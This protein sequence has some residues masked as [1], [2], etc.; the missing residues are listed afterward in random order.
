MKEIVSVLRKSRSISIRWSIFRTLLLLILLISGSLFLITAFTARS[1][2]K[3]LSERLIEDAVNDSDARLQGFFR[4]VRDDIL[5]LRDLIERG[6][7]N[8]R[9]PQDV[10]QVFAAILE[11]QP[12]IAAIFWGGSDGESFLVAKLEGRWIA[13]HVPADASLP[14]RRSVFDPKSGAVTAVEP[15]ERYDPRERPWYR[16]ATEHETREVVWTAP[17][18]F[19]TNDVIGVTGATEVRTPDGERIV[20]A[21]DVAMTRVL[22]FLHE[23]RPTPGG[24][25]FLLAPDGQMLTAAHFGPMKAVAAE[26]MA[27]EGVPLDALMKHA[28]MEGAPTVLRHGADW[29]CGIRPIQTQGGQ[30]FK[31]GVLIPQRDL[32]GD[33]RTFRVAL[34]LVTLGALVVATVLTLWVSRGY[35]DPIRKL[36]AQSQRIEKLDMND[37]LQLSSSLREV[38][39]LADAQEKMR[40]ALDSFARYVPVTVVRDL[41][42]QGAAAEIG[43]ELR[44]ITVIFSDIAG[45]TS[46]AERMTPEELTEHMG[47]YFDVMV[48]TFLKHDATVDKFIGDAIMAFWGAPRTLENHAAA[49]TRGVL[50]AKAALDELNTRWEVEGKVPLPTRF[51]IATGP[52]TVGNVG[53]AFRLSY[54]AL[55]DTVNL[56]QRLESLNNETNTWILASAETREAAGEEFEWREIGATQVKGREKYVSV[57]ELLGT[58]NESAA[59]TGEPRSDGPRETG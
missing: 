17:Y 3:A 42:R 23:M 6:K 38:S 47:E 12:Q 30:E 10:S 37:P 16:N 54:T 36:V 43:G 27:D 18:R 55:G 49:A 2:I 26:V 46:I 41:L 58:K 50:A 59:T 33:R 31:I 1:A 20:L 52:A 45:F 15:A 14:A 8:A 13:N 5:I 24:R 56:A 44:E 57:F 40:R 11:R 39:M 53:A 25:A 28:S 7:L 48:S 34:L 51:G 35:S 4:P 19:L 9:N 29:W 32:T 22:D 21:M